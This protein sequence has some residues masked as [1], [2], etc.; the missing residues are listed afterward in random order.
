MCIQKASFITLV[1]LTNIFLYCCSSRVV[2][3]SPTTTPHTPPIL[4][5]P[6]A[7]LP[8]LAL[9]MGPLYMFFDSPSS[10]FPHYPPPPPLWSLS[11][12]SLFPSL[13]FYFAHFS[14]IFINV[15]F[16]RFCVNSKIILTKE[17]IHIHC[18]RLGNIILDF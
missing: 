17:N 8:P 16:I 2:S 18:K 4:H 9:S 7:I 14:V 1:F 15:A 6:P 12:W 13:W 5:L 3:I 11:V 10:I